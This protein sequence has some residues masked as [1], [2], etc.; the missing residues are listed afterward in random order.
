MRI[1]IAIVM[2]LHGIAHLPGFIVPWRIATFKD[3]PYKTTLLSGRVDVGD[4]G[5]RIIGALW[6][7]VALAFV[8]AGIAA[9]IDVQW[10]P[11]AAASTAFASLILSFLS[12]PEARIGVVVNIAMLAVL[13]ISVAVGGP[14]TS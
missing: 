13:M 14:F 8:A 7:A 9:I 5:I 4:A 6:L 3:T 10:W 11:V 12:L 1:A 2:I